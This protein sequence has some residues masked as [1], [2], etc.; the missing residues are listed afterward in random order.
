M[1][2]YEDPILRFVEITLDILTESTCVSGYEQD[3]CPGNDNCGTKTA[4]A[5]AF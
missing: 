3:S 1:K 4:C 5:H 2:E